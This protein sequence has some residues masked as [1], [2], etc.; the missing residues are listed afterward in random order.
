[1]RP[2]LKAQDRQLTFGRIKSTNS[3]F[4]VLTAHK[5]ILVERAKERE[6]ELKKMEQCTQEAV[7]ILLTQRFVNKAHRDEPGI[8]ETA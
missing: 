7:L 1:M 6:D 5:Y 3:R 8:S 4:G 2:K